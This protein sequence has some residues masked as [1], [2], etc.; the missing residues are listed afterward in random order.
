MDDLFY[1]THSSADFSTYSLPSSPPSFAFRGESLFD[2]SPCFTLSTTQQSKQNVFYSPS[3][4]IFYTGH[5]ESSSMFGEYIL[6]EQTLEDRVF[7]L[8][9]Q[10]PDSPLTIN[11]LSNPDPINDFVSEDWLED[12]GDDEQTNLQDEEAETICLKEKR[13]GNITSLIFKSSP[14]IEVVSDNGKFPHSFSH[15][16]ALRTWTHDIYRHYPKRPSRA[17]IAQ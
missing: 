10:L 7:N 16:C 3:L 4:P 8:T 17:V 15:S 13:S 9:Y 14:S 2:D 5:N 12:F 1:E 6:N 11:E